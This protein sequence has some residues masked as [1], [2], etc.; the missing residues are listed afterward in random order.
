SLRCGSAWDVLTGTRTQGGHRALRSCEKMAEGSG[1]L[2]PLNNWG[3]VM[4]PELEQPGVNNEKEARRDRDLS[5]LLVRMI[6][7]TA[8]LSVPAVSR[9]AGRFGGEIGNQTLTQTLTPVRNRKRPRPH[10]LAWTNRTC[11]SRS[12]QL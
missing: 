6:A 12:P 4:A 5:Q 11:V 7:L 10:F 1:P 8:S 3:A 9:L 2:S